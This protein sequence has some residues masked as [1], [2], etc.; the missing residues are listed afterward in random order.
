[1]GD[2]TDTREAVLF[3]VAFVSPGLLICWF[4]NQLTQHVGENGLLSLLLIFLNIL[5]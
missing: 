2:Y 3:H 1:L 4:G 5:P